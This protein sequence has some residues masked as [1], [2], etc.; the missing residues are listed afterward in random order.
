MVCKMV[1]RMGFV[2]VWLTAV[3]WV[4]KRE[5]CLVALL[6]EQMV[7]RRVVQLVVYWVG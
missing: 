7:Q 4:L 6:V 5:D 2:R 1:W 3:W